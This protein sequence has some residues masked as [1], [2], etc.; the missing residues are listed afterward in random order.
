[1]CRNMGCN[2]DQCH[3]YTC[4][5]QTLFVNFIRNCKV[6]ANCICFYRHCS[7]TMPHVA[8]SWNKSVRGTHSQNFFGKI[9]GK[10]CRKALTLSY[11]R[12]RVDIRKF[13]FSNRVIDAWNSLPA[14]YVNSATINCFKT[15]VSVALELE[16]VMWNLAIYDSGVYMVQVCAHLCHQRRYLLM[17]VAMVNLVKS[18]VIITNFFYKS[19]YCCD[20]IYYLHDTDVKSAMSKYSKFA[21]RQ[22]KWRNGVKIML[23]VNVPR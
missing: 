14:L 18:C 8:R 3:L 9:F 2:L 17:L 1:M 10:I 21:F 23:S 6:N 11:K 13:S 5:S 4:C 19:T 7:T 16:T 22:L 12:K 15:H 20:I